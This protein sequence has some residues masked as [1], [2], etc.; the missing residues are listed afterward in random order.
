[1]VNNIIE[2]IGVIQWNSRSFI[3]FVQ[4]YLIKMS[5]LLSNRG[6]DIFTQSGFMYIFDKF[7]F[8]H[9]KISFEGVVIK[10]RG[11]AEFILESI[12]ILFKKKKN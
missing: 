5:N 7:N 10:I 1:M 4:K 9:I 3:I 6:V 12:I 11:I 2:S 8:N